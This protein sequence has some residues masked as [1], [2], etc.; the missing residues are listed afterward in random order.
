MALKTVK[1][2]LPAEIF[3]VAVN[4]P[5]IHQVVVAQQA[6]ARQGTHATKTRG[7]VRGGGKKPYKQKGTG[8][9]RQGS[10]RA[11]QFAGGGVVHG[12]QPRDYSQRTPKKMKAAALRGALSD[13]ARNDRVHVVSAFVDG[14]TPSTKAAAAALAKVSGAKHVLV[15]AERSDE[16][17]WL[18]LRNLPS[19]H[20]LEPGQ[21]NTYD[22][23]ISDDVVFTQ[24]ALEAFLAGPVKGRSAKGAA[25]SDE[26]VETTLAADDDVEV[27][28]EITKPAAQSEEDEA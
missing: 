16:L 15:V 8:R 1:V 11:P 6:A 10:T 21:L 9:A 13:R 4:V 14:D 17:T 19:V 22:V 18:S 28:V 3:D 24:G 23:L 26:L 12:P 7:E 2:D 27:A 20:V 25:T 5:L